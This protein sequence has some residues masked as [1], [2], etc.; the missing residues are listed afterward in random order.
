MQFIGPA[1]L[2]EPLPPGEWPGM[3]YPNLEPGPDGDFPGVPSWPVRPR[4]PI[5]GFA[6]ELPPDG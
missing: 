6:E 3:Y 2:N 4:P 1:T 5:R